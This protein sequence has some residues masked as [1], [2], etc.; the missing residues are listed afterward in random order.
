MGHFQQTFLNSKAQF[1][2]QVSDTCLCLPALVLS[3]FTS[4]EILFPW[5]S[6]YLQT[7]EFIKLSLRLSTGF[8][9]GYL[10]PET[11]RGA[12]SALWSLG[13]GQVFIP[14]GAGTSKALP[15][16]LC[17]L[18]SVIILVSYKKPNTYLAFLTYMCVFS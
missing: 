2:E 18:R 17:T 12:S 7:V 16:P 15:L 6:F 4:K 8:D 14:A 5:P 11:C 13:R 1:C 3:S 9:T 10:R